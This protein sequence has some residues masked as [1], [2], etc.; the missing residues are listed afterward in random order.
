M[1]E[2]LQIFVLDLCVV[3]FYN[4]VVHEEKVKTDFKRCREKRGDIVRVYKIDGKPRFQ[5]GVEAPV[6][7]LVPVNDLKPRGKLRH[8]RGDDVAVL[9]IEL[10]FRRVRIVAAGV[11]MEMQPLFIVLQLLR[12][13][14]LTRGGDSRGK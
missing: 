14:M 7:P 9:V 10:R 3:F 1:E 13:M 6:D 12:L 2:L 8:C 5:K 11:L 4:T